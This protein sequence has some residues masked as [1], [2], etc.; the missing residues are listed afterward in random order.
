[1]VSGSEDRLARWER[2]GAYHLTV[3][4]LLFIAVYAVPILWPGLDS[5][6][7]RACAVANVVIWALFGVDYLI[8]LGLS[9]RRAL[10]VRRH[11]FDLAVLILPVV[12]PSARCA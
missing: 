10:F 12:G 2:A 5:T 3:L 9:R 7:Q 11:W 8:R 6:W 4:S 1:M